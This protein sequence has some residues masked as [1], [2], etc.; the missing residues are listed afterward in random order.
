M[1]NPRNEPLTADIRG[2]AR[3]S[4]ARRGAAGTPVPDRPGAEHPGGG[5]VVPERAAR[6]V[7]E[8]KCILTGQH[9]DRDALIRLALSPDGDVLPD[10]L[11]R[12]PGR[13]AWIG[14]TRVELDQ[15][16]A[17]G[18]LKGALARAF[19]GTPLNIPVDLGDRIE[20]ALRRALADRLGIELR[21]GMI[22]LGTEKIAAAA[23]AGV[24]TFLGHASDAGGDGAGKLAQAWRVG[25]Q[26][27]GSGRKGVILPLDRAA[28][29]VALGRDN[30]VHL[31]LTDA[32]AAAR[33]TGLLGRLMHFTGC[34]PTGEA[35]AVVTDTAVANDEIDTKGE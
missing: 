11:A 14:V 35:T 23:R 7:P 22:V 15:A 9:D 19:K 1:R 26:A 30:V 27:E 25:E 24:V 12:A 29:S 33:V 8:R 2:K 20:T 5:G 21:S 34:R 18:K 13:G 4:A 32:A 3:G 17:K 16:I 28:L 31:A 10:V 6:A